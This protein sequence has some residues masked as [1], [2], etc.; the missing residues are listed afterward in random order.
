[1]NVRVPA[2]VFPPGEYVRDE[3]EARGW[4]QTDLA[5]ILGRPFRLVNEIIAGKRAITPETAKGLGEAF[6]TG[7]QFWMNLETVFRLSKAKGIEGD[8]SRRARIYGAAPIND[9]KKRHWINGEGGVEALEGEVLGFFGVGSIE[10]IATLPLAAAARKGTPYAETNPSQL[11][12]LCQVKRIACTMPVPPY[13]EAD[14]DR[15]SIELHRLT[16][17]ENEVRR[18]PQLLASYG[19]RF[20]VVE[21][22]PKTRIDGAALWLDPQSPVIALSIRHDRIDAFWHTLWHELGHI[23]YR[24]ATGIDDDIV[25]ESAAS[26]DERPEAEI[27]ADA[28]ACDLLVPKIEIES[29]IARV[30]P[31]YSRVR[32][33]QFAN[34]IQVHPGIIIGQLQHRKEIKYSQ[35]REM[36]VKIRETIVQSA[37]TDGWGHYPPAFL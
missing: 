23:K 16:A 2:E 27:V 26:R 33:N 28:F 35:G 9:M 10:E 8:V 11:A 34:R 29:F 6:G 32:I 7:P 14:F 24:H 5:E 25:G 1:M 31:L 4:S 18:V 17:S 19:V 12:W 36:L 21:H 30:R 37:V 20:L 15:M 22:L 13:R 3:L